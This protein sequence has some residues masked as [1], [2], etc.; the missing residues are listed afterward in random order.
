[1]AKK[2]DKKEAKIVLEREY[3][4]PLRREFIKAPKWKSAQKASKGLRKFLIK[5]MKPEGM[6]ATNV[7][8]GKYLNEKVWMHGIKNPP[9]HV[10]IIAKKDDKGIVTAELVGATE[11]K[12][13][14]EKGKKKEIKKDTKIEEKTETKKEV[15]EEKKPAAK[16]EN[17]EEKKEEKSDEQQ[18]LKEEA[19]EKAPQAE[20]NNQ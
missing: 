12:K 9:H 15:K 8:I 7:K 17:V 2:D 13:V 5:H 19:G 10:K 4:V 14:E 3:N 11:E 18:P 6:L 1:M 20:E 16:E